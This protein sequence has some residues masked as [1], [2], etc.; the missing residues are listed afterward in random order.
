MFRLQIEWLDNGNNKKALQEAEKVLKKHPNFDCCRVLKSLALIRMNREN[1]AVPI[2]DSVMENGTT[3]DGAL[4]ALNV[5]FKELH[6][7]E[8]N[9]LLS[10]S[11]RFPY[12]SI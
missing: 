12:S 2:I 6:Q 7:R 1:E 10:I 11:K 9:A 8:L 4:Q 5:A 3:D